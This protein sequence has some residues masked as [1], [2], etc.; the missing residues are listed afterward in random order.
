MLHFVCVKQL[1][2]EIRYSGTK[3]D[4]REII[5][6]DRLCDVVALLCQIFASKLI[7]VA[8]LV[9]VETLSL[10]DSTAPVL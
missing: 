9:Q 1:C 3:S 7:T 6:T 2:I 10:C 8:V 4:L 5:F